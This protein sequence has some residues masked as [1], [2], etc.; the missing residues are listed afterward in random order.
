MEI[1]IFTSQKCLLD[2]NELKVGRTTDIMPIYKL[3]LDGPTYRYEAETLTLKSFNRSR[4]S[5]H[6]CKTD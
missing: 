5:S 4:G 3:T 2:S 6:F 1:E